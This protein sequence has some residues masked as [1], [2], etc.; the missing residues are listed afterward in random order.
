MVAAGRREY[1]KVR[2]RRVPA[3]KR[4]KEKEL[5]LSVKICLE[6][7]LPEDPEILVNSSY[8]DATPPVV[9]V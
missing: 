6:E 5:E 8:L 1:R 9:I 7:E 2:S 3:A 4:S